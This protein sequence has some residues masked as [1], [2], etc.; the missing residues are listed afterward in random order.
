MSES[1]L[2]FLPVPARPTCGSPTSVS[3]SWRTNVQLQAQLFPAACLR[4]S[5]GLLKAHNDFIKR[6]R[7][8]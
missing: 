4:C 5:A 8:Q 3:S 2:F 6:T 7:A 1:I